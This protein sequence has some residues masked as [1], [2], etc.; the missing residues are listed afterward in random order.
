[1][2]W[3]VPKFPA[4]RPERRRPHLAHH[5]RLGLTRGISRI[6]SDWIEVLSGALGAVPP[7]LLIA[8]AALGGWRLGGWRLGLL[9]GQG[10]PSCGTC[11]S[12]SRR[13]RR[14]S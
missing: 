14:S 11:A 7:W 8:L 13:S 5:P 1:M 9:A 2:D 12:G 3:D 4:R 6:V 10:S